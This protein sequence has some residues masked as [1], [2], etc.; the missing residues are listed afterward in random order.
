MVGY[1]FWTK[2]SHYRRMLSLYSIAF[3]D[4]YKED[5]VKNPG[6]ANW[7]SQGAMFRSNTK[8][9]L[10]NPKHSL[11]YKSASRSLG[12]VKA[13]TQALACWLPP[14]WYWGAVQVLV[15]D[16]TMVRISI[17]LYYLKIQNRIVLGPSCAPSSTIFQHSLR[18]DYGHPPVRHQ[19]LL[20]SG[21]WV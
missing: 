17:P 7:I 3:D 9:K 4:Q 16:Y 18:A 12:A 6:L 19:S 20:K 13:N 15:T 2:N 14:P 10:N 8:I 1:T 5:L 11:E 21:R